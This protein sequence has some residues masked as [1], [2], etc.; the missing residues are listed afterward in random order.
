MNGSGIG[1][2]SAVSFGAASFSI[3][4]LLS[5]FPFKF[6]ST[7]ALAAFRWYSNLIRS[8]LKNGMDKRRTLPKDLRTSLHF[9]LDC[10]DHAV[11]LMSQCFANR[12]KSFLANQ[13]SSVPGMNHSAKAHLRVRSFPLRAAISANGWSRGIPGGGN[14]GGG[15]N[16][17][18]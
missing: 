14:G 3:S 1:I 9:F 6:A 7:F 15:D 13:S 8:S 12:L 16:A 4:S 18:V 2:N 10:F 5:I 11:S 17:N